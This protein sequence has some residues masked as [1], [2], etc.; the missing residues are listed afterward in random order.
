M[1]VLSL[2]D[3][4]NKENIPAFSEGP[5]ISSV[6]KGWSRIPLEDVTKIFYPVSV[7]SV[8]SK[9]ISDTT[10]IPI[11]SCTYLARRGMNSRPRKVARA[12]LDSLILKSTNT[13]AL[14][15]GFR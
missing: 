10:S 6:K 12:S 15:T 7:P 3:S 8:L 9:P 2:S 13:V 4:D 1:A 5:A 14:R 11:V